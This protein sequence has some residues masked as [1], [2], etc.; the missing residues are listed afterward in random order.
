MIEL[1]ELKRRYE[2]PTAD[3]FN[4]ATAKAS[5]ASAFITTDMKRLLRK[6]VVDAFSKYARILDPSQ[7]RTELFS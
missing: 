2:I 4:V 1:R 3:L 5:L 6:D 7:A